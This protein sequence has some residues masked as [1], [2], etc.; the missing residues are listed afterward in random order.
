MTKKKIFY[1]IW[2]LLPMLILLLIVPFSVQALESVQDSQYLKM[3]SLCKDVEEKEPV[4]ETTSF[5]VWDERVFCWIRFNYSSSE[6]FDITWEWEDPKGNIY[7]TG[8]LEMEPGDYQNY[9]T[10][11]GIGIQD[12]Y[13]VNLPG[14]W[15]V[16]VSLDDSVV[17]VK[18]FTIS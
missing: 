17:A 10:W 16:R 13:A 1:T 15:I 8:K 18:N 14:E 12:H 11:Y 6:I 5:S 3:I 7:H 4:L 2:G 9:R